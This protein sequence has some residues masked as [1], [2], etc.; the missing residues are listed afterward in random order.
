M[1]VCKHFHS[2]TE[3]DI[4]FNDEINGV[5]LRKLHSEAMN[6][7]PIPTVCV[8]VCAATGVYLASSRCQTGSQPC[9]CGRSVK[10]WLPTPKAPQSGQLKWNHTC[11]QHITQTPSKLPSTFSKVLLHRKTGNDGKNKEQRN[12]EGEDNMRKSHSSSVGVWHQSL[13]S[14]L[15]TLATPAAPVLWQHWDPVPYRRTVSLSLAA[16]STSS[17]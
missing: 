2:N 14:K 6:E 13:S 16:S 5:M 4:V 17:A 1:Y 9:I 10:I 3:K 11:S 7:S 8:F 15:D 12:K